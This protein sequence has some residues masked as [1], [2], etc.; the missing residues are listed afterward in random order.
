MKNQKTI[1]ITI[2]IAAIILVYLCH[3]AGML[4]GQKNTL[5]QVINKVGIEMRSLGISFAI[6]ISVL[7]VFLVLVRV[8]KKP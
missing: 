5:Q 1:D 6:G 3:I 2:A 7:L 4:W 8:F